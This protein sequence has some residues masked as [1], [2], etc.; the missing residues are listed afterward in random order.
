MLLR[1]FLDYLRLEQNVSPRT[2]NAYRD[3]LMAFESFFKEL[4]S[5]LTWQTIDTDVARQ[6]V[7]AMM[8]RGNKASSIQR[9]LS[10]LRS[11]FRFFYK[12]GMVEQDPVRQLT[13]PKQER[14]L[15]NF[16][17]EEDMD[18]LLDTPGMFEDSFEG[19]RD[20]LIVA[21]FYETG[22]RL[23][24][25]VG[26][27]VADVNLRSKSLKVLGKGSKERIV[28][29]GEGLLHLINIYIG[30]RAYYEHPDADSKAFFIAENGKRLTAS[31][32][33]TMVKAQLG[34]VTTQTK[35]SPHVLRHTFATTMLNHEADLESVKEL[36]GHER[37]Q[38]TEI[39]THTT[40][41]ELK[42][43]YSEAHPRA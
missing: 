30:E 23:S 2:W 24:E 26:L 22:L 35:R 33:R 40:F 39:Y 25:L 8:E 13:A 28:P 34:L 15:P 18:R 19:R 3:D 5:N 20:R 42:K 6:W 1:A 21:M 7:V 10:A 43:V 31:Q 41:E 4:D 14:P 9:R 11:C 32:V 29:F 12:R 37:L 38:T 36:L 16:I 17:R 27:D